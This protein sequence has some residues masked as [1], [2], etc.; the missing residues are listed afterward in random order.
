MHPSSRSRRRQLHVE[1]EI[2]EHQ[3]RT[4]KLWAILAP[5][6]AVLLSLQCSPL[7][8]ADTYQLVSLGNDNVSFYGLAASGQVAFDSYHSYCG[9]SS[10]LCYEENGAWSSA[11]P[12]LTWDNGAACTPAGTSSLAAVCNSGRTAYD[13]FADGTPGP[14]S[15]YSVSGSDPA[16]LIFTG[17]LIGRL[18]MNGAGDIVFDNGSFEEWYE[19]IDLTN[20]SVASTVAISTTATTAAEPASFLLLA[21]GILAPIFFLRRRR[22]AALGL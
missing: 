10:S 17:S 16:Q 8:H 15:L 11:A 6:A 19:A 18:Y 21:T 14:V 22:T 20:P 5:A 9:P 12:A 3:L 7:A 1:V 2:K 4:S 13:Q